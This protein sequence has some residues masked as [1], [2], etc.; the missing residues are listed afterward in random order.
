M[1]NT[2]L[3]WGALTPASWYLA[4]RRFSL[5]WRLRVSLSDVFV[6]ADYTRP[7]QVAGTIQALEKY[8]VP[9]LML[10]R[11]MYT[12]SSS[13][14]ASD[15]LGPLRAYLHQSYRLTKQKFGRESTLEFGEL[16]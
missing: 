5:P 13:N 11:D 12:P 6:P 7:E 3:R 1:M 15:H 10:H 4:L 9:L 8:R 14:S 16:T 2:A